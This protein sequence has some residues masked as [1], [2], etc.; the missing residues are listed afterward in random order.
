MQTLR[1]SLV[2]LRVPALL[3]GVIEK[4]HLK[5]SFLEDMVEHDLTW[6]DFWKSQ[7][8]KSESSS[9]SSGGGGGGGGGDGGGG[10]CGGCSSL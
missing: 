3:V 10:G 7:L 2:A 5:R 9:S 8:N 4:S 1:R 6:S